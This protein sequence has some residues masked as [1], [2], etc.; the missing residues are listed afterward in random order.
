M[1]SEVSLHPIYI[2]HFYFCFFNFN[3]ALVWPRY[4]TGMV[5]EALAH[6]N[7]CGLGFIP[8]WSQKLLQLQLQLRPGVAS[9]LYRYGPRGSSS[10]PTV[11]PRYETKGPG[12]SDR[13]D[14]PG[15]HVGRPIFIAAPMSCLEWNPPGP[16]AANHEHFLQLWRPW[17]G[18]LQTQPQLIISIHWAQAYRG[19]CCCFCKQKPK[20]GF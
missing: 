8:V 6:C 4:Y 16:E 14:D 11:R 18:T 12:D 9:V 10:L 17:M 1:V 5:P 3:Y 20:I 19:C 2:L 7:W 13:P 15:D